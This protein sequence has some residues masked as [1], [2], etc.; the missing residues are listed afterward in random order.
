MARVPALAGTCELHGVD[1]P[2]PRAARMSQADRTDERH[3]TFLG[4]EC[5]AVG[6]PQRSELAAGLGKGNVTCSVRSARK[7]AL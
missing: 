6:T 4:I 7:Q 2:R 5:K 3:S 1:Q